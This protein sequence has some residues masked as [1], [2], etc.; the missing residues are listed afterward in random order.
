M[1]VFNARADKSYN[2]L[3]PTITVRQLMWALK[4][5]PLKK[6]R[7]ETCFDRKDI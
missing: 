5:K 3:Y 2:G 1:Q 7:W 4:I 6:E